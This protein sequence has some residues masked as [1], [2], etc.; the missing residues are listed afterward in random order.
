MPGKGCLARKAERKEQRRRQIA[1]EAA[2]EAEA[3]GEPLAKV[4]RIDDDEDPD[5][6]KIAEEFGIGD[7]TT[8]AVPLKIWAEVPP[9]EALCDEDREKAIAL[10]R[11][12]YEACL[13]FGGEGC[14]VPQLGSHYKVQ[15]LKRDPCFNRQRLVDILRRHEDVFELTMAENGGHKVHLQPGAMAACPGEAPIA[16]PMLSSES[17][18]PVLE[19]PETPE[20]KFQAL[21]VHVVHSLFKRGGKAVLHDLGQ[22]PKIV[23]LRKQILNGRS[24]LQFIKVFPFNFGIEDLGNGNFTIDLAQLDVSETS[25]IKDAAAEFA[26]EFVRGPKGGGSCK[27]K[28]K[29]D[30]RCKFPVNPMLITMMKGKMEEIQGKGKGKGKGSGFDG[31]GSSSSSFMPAFPPMM[32]MQM[33]MKGKAMSKGMFGG[34][35]WGGGWDSWGGGGCGGKGSWGDPWGSWSDCG[36]GAWGGDDSWG[37]GSWPG[38]GG[39]GSASSGD[40][41]VWGDG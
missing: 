15:Q 31:M 28:G 4:A 14:T 17:L 34:G 22:D 13:G 27:G 16:P 23:E 12:L 36:G 26:T 35:S 24:L 10:C 6:A 8:P 18:P 9:L 21:R 30:G 41:G 1:A 29:N 2:A 5:L 3:N 11:A 40:M 20:E 25:M 37:G 19:N 7:A 32:M 39:A 38:F 33:F